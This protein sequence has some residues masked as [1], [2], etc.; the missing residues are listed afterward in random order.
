MPAA[1]AELRGSSTL[2]PSALYDCDGSWL[3]LSDQRTSKHYEIPLRKV[4]SLAGSLLTGVRT[5]M[6]HFRTIRT[7]KV[8]S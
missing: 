3:L 6:D 5:P 4:L 1:P 8:A 7:V 2:T